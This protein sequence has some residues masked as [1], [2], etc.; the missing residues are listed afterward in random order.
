MWQVE[1][2]V[3][4]FCIVPL[5]F[6]TSAQAGE[7]PVVFEFE[8]IDTS[9]EDEM[10]GMDEAEWTRLARF[11]DQACGFCAAAMARSL[12][13]DLAVTGTVQKV[14]DLILNINLDLPDA[15][16]KQLVRSG[17]VDTRGNT[18]ES[19]SR[20]LRSLVKNRLFKG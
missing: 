18:D 10:T 3:T 9:L 17:S 12:G 19:W 14:S 4:L 16:T 1:T 7:K 15:R 6:I 8:F 5:A 13:S 11:G 2:L 20:G